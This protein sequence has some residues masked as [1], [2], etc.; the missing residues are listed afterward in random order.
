MSWRRRLLSDV[1][2]GR[3]LNCTLVGGIYDDEDAMTFRLPN[4]SRRRGRVATPA[5][6]DR[7][8][9]DEN[10]H[11]MTL[12]LN[13]APK[14][15]PVVEQKNNASEVNGTSNDRQENAVAARSRI[16]KL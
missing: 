4:R 2:I 15:P 7:V 14:I 11:K 9:V 1:R 12:L 3:Q 10:V 16:V 5:K 8:D 13:N 6:D